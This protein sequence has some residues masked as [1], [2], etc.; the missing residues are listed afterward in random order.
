WSQGYRSG[1]LGAGRVEERFN[2][3]AGSALEDVRAEGF[4]GEPTVL[5]SIS[6]RYL[7]QN[8][9]QDIPVP[10]GPITAESLREVMRRFDEQHERFYGH[11]IDG[12]TME[13]IHFKVSAIGQH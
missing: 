5:R 8:Y 6:M 11:H 3:V 12:E 2:A 4:A 10:S 13:F 9:E 7:G 1:R